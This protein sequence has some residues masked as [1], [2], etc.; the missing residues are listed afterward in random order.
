MSPA[1]E[2]PRRAITA[3]AEWLAVTQRTDIPDAVVARAGDCVLDAVGA[4]LAGREEQSSRVMAQ[5][6]QAAMAA[7][8]A[9]LWFEG[10]AVGT[11]AAAAANAMAATALDIDDGHRK[12]AGHPGE[13]VV[14]AACAV[15]EEVGASADEFAVALVCGYEAAVR[16]ALAR[17]P[18]HHDSTVSGRWSG[19]G[20]AAAAARL[21]RV[22]PEQM[23]QA[24][25]IAEQHAPRVS[26]ALHH[27]FAGSD[28]KEGIAWSV[29]SGLMAVDLARAGF[30]GYPDAFDQNILYDPERLV[31]DLG[32]FGA[33]DGL[34]F[35]P[36]ACCRW[37][38]AAIDALA[39]IIAEAALA[40][41]DIDRVEVETFARG[42]G[43]GNHVAPTDGAQAQFSFPFCLGVTAVAGTAALLPL[44]ETLIGD[45]RIEAFARKVSVGLAPDMEA[46]FPALAPARV[47][48]HCA[49]RRFARTVKAAFGDPGNPMQRGDLRAKFRTLAH[50]RLPAH[51]IDRIEAALALETIPGGQPVNDALEPIMAPIS[52]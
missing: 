38:H 8:T 35:K 19:I 27:G 44:D 28:V 29:H 51:R 10:A 45:Q 36:Y 7:G 25:L 22:T 34:F 37:I 13:A 17:H 46:H 9:R 20:A 24:I 40:P 1:A 12:A 32:R 50:P 31:A 47:I 52:A 42:A 21:H 43:L 6:M 48:V 23:A 39:G 41:E 11:I 14:A 49:G 30:R 3:L 2:P 33:I 18:R 16:V 4:A 15:A 5:V 26:A